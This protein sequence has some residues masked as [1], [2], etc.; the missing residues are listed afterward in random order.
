MDL[1]SVITAGSVAVAVV[2]VILGIVR[3]LRQAATRTAD[4]RLPFLDEAS[5]SLDHLGFAATRLSG[6]S[7]SASDL[8]Q[9]NIGAHVASLR[10]AIRGL[11][12]KPLLLHAASSD[13]FTTQRDKERWFAA[14][15]A[16]TDAREVPPSDG[17]EHQAMVEQVRVSE[18]MRSAIEFVEE[19]VA[20][21]RARM[22]KLYRER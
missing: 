2:G 11:G 12:D 19:C 9:L 18:R 7:L 17:S 4:R 20:A 22:R 15:K 8:Q 6:G 13:E 16:I 5:A 3:Y 10:K 1:Q 21:E 14:L